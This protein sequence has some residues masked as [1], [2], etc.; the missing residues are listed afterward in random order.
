MKRLWA[1]RWF[2][3]VLGVL[4]TVVIPLVLLSVLAAL[5]VNPNS[6]GSP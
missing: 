6:G 4:V 1:T 2:R 5:G 3:I